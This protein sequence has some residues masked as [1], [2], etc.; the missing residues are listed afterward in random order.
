M[1]SRR[2]T[3]PT[4]RPFLPGPPIT[5]IT[6]EAKEPEKATLYLDYKH[7]CAYDGPTKGCPECEGSS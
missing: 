6:P 1:T 5:G 2:R 4:Q 7:I 3:P